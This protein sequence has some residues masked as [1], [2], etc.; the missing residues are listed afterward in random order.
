M[1]ALIPFVALDRTSEQAQAWIRHQLVGA[2]L[3]VVQTFDL[4]VA[5]MAHPDFPCT[6][7]GTAECDCQMVVLLVY[8]REAEPATLVI[9]SQDGTTWLS[10]AGPMGV[11]SD[12]HLEAAI[13]RILL[14]RP[15]NIPSSVEA[16]L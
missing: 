4:Q 8:D 2:G 15:A 11:R 9:H 10:L 3:R 12:R 16:S 14:P 6:H 5:R 7:H 13:R 1:S